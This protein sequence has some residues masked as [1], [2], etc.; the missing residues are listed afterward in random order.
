MK[1]PA[2]E[3]SEPEASVKPLVLRADD[4]SDPAGWIYE[5]LETERAEWNRRRGFR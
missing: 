3:A 2:D 5:A 1:P 4:E